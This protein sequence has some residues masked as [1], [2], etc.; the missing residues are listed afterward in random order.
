MKENIG[1][2]LLQAR[3]ARALSLEQA[4]QATRIR[5]HYLKAM[6]AGDFEALPSNAQVRGFLRAY[7]NYLGLKTE[8]LLAELAEIEAPPEIPTARRSRFPGRTAR[9]DP[10]LPDTAP[11]ANQVEPFPAPT[12][13]ESSLETVPPE[14]P[15]VRSLAA[16]PAVTPPDR[17]SE[18]D[19]AGSEQAAAIF[20][21]IGQRLQHQRE[22]L[23]IS[24]DDVVRYTHLRRH[25][26]AALEAGSLEG[27]PSPVQ[28][29]GM[30]NNY[31]VF[32]G[33]DPEPL[34]LRFAEGL[35]A[36]L[37]VQQAARSQEPSRAQPRPARRRWLMPA[38]LRRLFSSDL[39]IGG[40]LT[41]FLIAFVTWGAVRIFAMRSQ[42]APSPT[43]PSIADVL[44][45]TITSTPTL[46][47]LPGS[48]QDALSEAATPGA[49][50]PVA[51]L[52][53]QAG[54]TEIVSTQALTT[55][56]K[57]TARAK[58]NVQVYVTVHQRAWMEVKVDGK[59]EFQGRVLPNSA[60][61]FAGEKQVEIL[62]GNAAALQVFF[63]QQDM[64]ALGLFGQI[65]D[66]IYTA[67]GIVSPTPTTTPTI[68]PPP[69]P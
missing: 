10:A 59:I 61:S 62:T 18:T 5:L 14:A 40:T 35:Q 51:A 8:P 66:Q 24:L 55:T 47:P 19:K 22:L 31:A 44:L 52:P 53:S 42:Q 25:Y 2:Q 43:A 3:Q 39:L 38:P 36:R 11:A 29:R 41:I 57:G 50:H 20:T 21:E 46:T 60:Y 67:N 26:L 23:G 48:T 13:D 32:L 7:A 28:G 12:P 68:T 4:A 33:L 34:L 17:K 30:L 63:G 65:V 49:G 9:P 64:G 56:I 37:A 1:Q 58:Q 45:A 6:E 15:G 54:A 69:P 16:I 27:L